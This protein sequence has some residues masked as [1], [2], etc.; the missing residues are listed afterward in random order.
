[1]TPYVCC[2]DDVRKN[3]VRDGSVPFNGIDFLE[4]VDDGTQLNLRVH[5]LKP[6][7]IA[8][9]RRNVRIEGGERVLDPAIDTTS[10]SGNVLSVVVVEPGDFTPYTLRLV[11]GPLSDDPPAG[12]DPLLAAVR[13]TF[14]V[15]CPSDFDCRVERICPSED[16]EAPQIDY[17]AKDYASFRQLMLDRLNVLMPQWRSREAADLGVVLVELL[18]YVGDQLSYFQDAVATEAYLGTARR[19][20]SVRRHA[21]LVD[22]RMHDGCNARAWVQ[23]QLPQDDLAS[24]DP[25]IVVGRGARLLTA[26][27]GLPPVLDEPTYRLALGSRPEVFETLHDVRVYRANQEVRFYTWGA[28]ECCLPTGSTAA[29]LIGRPHLAA[30]DVLRIETPGGGGYGPG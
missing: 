14:K 11:Q 18:A 23:I 3:A 19:R 25:G 20:V 28:R 5:F 16:V 26:V 17:L 2:Q 29:T 24:P 8:L 6:I 12:I 30:G 15:N 9:D 22:Y 21:R 13:F 27:P 1:L 7:G 10:V 4:V